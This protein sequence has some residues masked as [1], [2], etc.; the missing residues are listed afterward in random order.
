MA[1]S[2]RRGLAWMTLSQGGL[3]VMQFGASLVLA[4]L[5][6]PYETGVFAVAAAM[7]GLLGMLRTIGLSSYVIR[8]PAVDAAFLAGVFTVNAVLSAAVSVLIVAMSLLGGHLLGEPG[9]RDVLMLLAVVPLLACLELLPAACI[10]RQGNFRPIAMINLG[11]HLVATITM[12]GFVIAGHSYMSLAYG[13]VAGAVVAVVA[14]NM[15][16]RRFVSLRVSLQGWRDITRYG[17]DMLA[18]TG[19]ASTHLRLLDIILGW[20]LGLHALGIYARAAGLVMMLWENFQA[21]MMRVLFV[22]LVAQRRMGLSF[23]HTYLRMMGINTALLWPTFGGLAVVSGP[24]LLTL[25]GEQWVGGAPV[26]SLL[27]ISGLIGTTLLMA[28]EIFLALEQTRR[29]AKF[30]AVQSLVGAVMFAVGCL[31][32]IA[33]AAGAR[34]IEALFG[35]VLYRPHLA[36]MA[37]VNR[38]DILPI[39]GRS[40]MLTVL[41][42]APA[43]V[44]MAMHDWSAY[45]PLLQV[46]PAVALGVVCWA[47]G[48]WQFDHALYQEVRRMAGRLGGSAVPGATK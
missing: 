30:Q 41:A 20:M 35:V 26:L 40:A 39:L 33:G 38:G 8:A 9:V 1:F 42:V 43:A 18:T 37:E 12:L 45:A 11:R 34:I 4:R 31:G 15:V 36:R 25:Y 6:T 19:I 2:V 28:W 13:Q 3:V 7:A 44:V 23:R 17:L 32:G 24:V 5:L 27:S 47:V 46:L 22:D 16:G 29:L 48:L 21:I 14:I 10:E